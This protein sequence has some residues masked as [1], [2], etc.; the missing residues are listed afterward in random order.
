MSPTCPTRPVLASNDPLCELQADVK[1]ALEALPFYFKSDIHIS[2]LSATDIFTLSGALG[3]TIEDQVVKTLNVLRSTWDPV[4]LYAD[5][6]FVRQAQTF[7]DVLLRRNSV[8]AGPDILLGIELK[9]WY[10]LAKEREPSLRFQVTPAACA[11]IDLVVV[12][13]WLLSAVVSGSPEVLSPFIESARY[14]A[15][16]RN[17]WWEHMRT[18]TADKRIDLSTVNHPYPSKQEQITDKPKADGGNN[19]GRMPRVTDDQGV[20]FMDAFTQKIDGENVLGVP[21]KF[22]RRFFKL[23][24][25]GKDEAT[26]ERQIDTLQRDMARAGLQGTGPRQALSDA[27]AALQSLNQTLP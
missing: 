19:F 1:K 23:F 9:G 18:T 6:A 4:D 26:I 8:A 15:E 27:V 24:S 17:H 2:R 21:L 13:P 22:W 5:Y 3:A 11:D 20:G 25:E 7:P 10:A 14:A 16:L 12:V